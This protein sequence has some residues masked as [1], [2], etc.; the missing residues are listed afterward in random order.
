MILPQSVND[1]DRDISLQVSATVEMCDH[2]RFLSSSVHNIEAMAIHS[3]VQGLFRLTHVLKTTPP[4]LYQIHNVGSF[5][6]GT[7]PKEK[8]LA[9]CFTG[10]HIHGQKD[11][12]SFAP[13]CH[14]AKVARDITG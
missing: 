10:K 8:S 11:Q 7:H 12:A 5:A 3:A 14:T 6:G 13:I 9:Y 1:H 2:W 4:A